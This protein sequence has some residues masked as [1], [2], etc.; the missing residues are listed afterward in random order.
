MT[1]KLFYED[2]HLFTFSARLL[3]YE[4]EKNG[5]VSAVLDRTAFFPGGG[6]QLADTGQLEGVRIVNVH[7]RNGEIFH[8][9]EEAPIAG[10]GEGGEVLCFVDAEKRLRRMQNHSGEHVLSGLGKLQVL[11]SM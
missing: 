3:R 11:E 6:G 7:E 4:T 5:Q 9:L 2:S 1:E 8:V 10:T